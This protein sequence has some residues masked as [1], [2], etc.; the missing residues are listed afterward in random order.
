MTYRN[1]LKKKLKK[2]KTKRKLK[3]KLKRKRRKNKEKQ[4]KK[5]TIVVSFTETKKVT[6]KTAELIGASVA[7]M[8]FVRKILMATQE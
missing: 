3:R 6:P 5:Q 8:E 1:F 4:R 7:K 2:R